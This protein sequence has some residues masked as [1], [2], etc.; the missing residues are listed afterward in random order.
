MTDVKGEIRRII[1][2][3]GYSAVFQTLKVCAQ[4][5]YTFLKTVVASSESPILSASSS[6]TQPA[7]RPSQPPS[8]SE[9]KKVS[10][11]TNVV[12]KKEGRRGRKPK[13]LVEANAPTGLEEG[14]RVVQ[15]S[16]V[17]EESEQ[18]QRQEQGQMNESQGKYRDA[19]EVKLWQRDQEQKKRIELDAQ[20]ITVDSLLTKENLKKW[21]EEEGRTYADVARTY[22]GCQ[23]SQVSSAAKLYGIQSSNSMKRITM[24][25]KRK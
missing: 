10:K 6:S 16:P 22:V 25:N 12:V 14:E 2:Q 17:E 7:Q 23:D 19:K 3:F 8:N 5:D 13:Q 21:I 11:L 24:L 15:V 9:S 1:G 18:G 4:E 20:G